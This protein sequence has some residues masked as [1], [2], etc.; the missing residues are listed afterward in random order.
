MKPFKLLIVAAV[1]MG[2]MTLQGCLKEEVGFEE[3]D[4]IVITGVMDKINV[5]LADMLSNGQN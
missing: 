2:C 3:A 5:F 4:G 1:A